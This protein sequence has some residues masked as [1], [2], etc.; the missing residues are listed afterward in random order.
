SQTIDLNYNTFIKSSLLNFSVYYRHID[1]VIENIARPIPVDSL[2]GTLTQFH[3]ADVNH[4]FG[5]NF[6]TSINP[7]KIL[8]LRTNINVYT[9]NPTPYPQYVLDFTNTQTKV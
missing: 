7:I 9:Y 6:F 2:T 8:T 1:G 4:S 5:F 3:N